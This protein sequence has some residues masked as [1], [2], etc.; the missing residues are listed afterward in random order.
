MT[1]P[2]LPGL[3]GA[4]EPVLNHYGYLAVAGLVLVE[5]FGIPVPGET[6]LIAASLYAGAGRLNVVAVGVIATLAAIT[7]DNIGFAIGHFGGRALALRYGKYVFLTA[8]RLDKAEYFFDRHGGKII[9]AA[10]FIEGLR[11]ANGIVA[12][13]TG[14]HW[15]KFVVFNTLG[16][17]LWVGVW[18]T[19]GYLAG[20][21]IIT[22]YDQVTRYSLYLLIAL[23]VLIAALIARW[24]LRRRARGRTR[25]ASAAQ[26]SPEPSAPTG[27][28]A[29][30]GV[31]AS[32]KTEKTA[33]I[34][35]SSGT[36]ADG[37]TE[38]GEAAA[39]A[40]E[41]GE[42]GEAA[43]EAGEAKEARDTAE[44]A[45]SQDGLA[46]D[47]PTQ[48]GLAQDRPTQD[49]LAQDRPTQ[50]GLAQDRPTQDGLTQDREACNGEL[51][52]RTAPPAAG[53]RGTPGQSRRG[54]S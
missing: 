22:I 3:F 19:L 14:M 29:A 31:S 34:S 1:S 50:D 6:I 13:I 11:Q 46:Q 37:T 36:G 49:G 18:V 38:A 23:V 10:R 20:N 52:D 12:G 48:D 53:D 45:Q 7:G 21:H 51:A 40:G 5:D 9:V 47:R 30:S 27:T 15:K 25:A 24:L 43:A 41:A 28:A 26:A 42:A 8:E 35:A 32:Q 44:P 39:E 2:A 16:A 54:S 4:L 33:E 17:A